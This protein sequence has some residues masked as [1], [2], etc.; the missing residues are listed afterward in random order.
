MSYQY[1][2][3]AT[4][5]LDTETYVKRD[6]DDQLYNG[7][8]QGK[9]CCVFNSRKTGKSSL[10]VQVVNR[11]QNE[12][13]KNEEFI[14]IEIDFSQKGTTS[15]TAEKWYNSLILDFKKKIKLDINIKTW[16]NAHDWLSP[17]DRFAEFIDTIVL[18]QTSKKIIVFFDEIDSLLSLNF[19]TDDLFSYIRSWHNQGQ[20]GEKNYQRLTCCLLGTATPSD[21]IQDKNRTSFNIGEE[22]ELK[23]FN[24]QQVE[25]LEKGFEGKV[26]HPLK[27]LE[28]IL[29]WTGGQPFLTQKLCKLALDQITETS[30]LNLDEL[31]NSQ[32]L[33]NW[34]VHDNP[35]HLRTIRD[36]L[37]KD[38]K[39]S[40][41]LLGI[42][43]QLLNSPNQTLKADDS[44]DQIKLRLSGLVVKKNGN[45]EVYNRIYQAVFNLNWVEKELANQR[46]F[47]HENLVAWRTSGRIDTRQLL[48]G[49]ILENALKEAE[50]KRLSDEDQDF[51]NASRDYDRQQLKQAKEK[52]TKI[53]Q[54]AQKGTQLERKGIQTLRLFNT[55]IDQRQTLRD[56][57]QAG[58]DLQQLQA[59]WRELVQDDPELLKQTPAASPVFTLPEILSHIRQWRQ[60]TGHS[61]SV[62]AVAFSPGGEFLATAS[63]D[64]TAKLW[65]LQGEEL[66]TFTGHSNSVW[67]VAFSPG[68]EFLATASHDKTAKLW[69][70]QGEELITFTGHSYGLRAVAFSPGGEFLATASGDKTAK[71]WNLQGEE[72]I[73]TFTGHSGSLWGVAFSPGGEFLATASYDKTAK[74][75]NLQGE[76]LITFTGHSD[77][78][79]GVAFSPGGEFLATA[80]WDNTT[81][82]WNLDRKSVV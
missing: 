52:A 68:G 69:N 29:S 1:I 64:K 56:A 57:I 72:L 32:I 34:E 78:L 28:Q 25:R 61:N 81:K 46:K 8:K 5:P 77:S 17:L 51:L 7:L 60:L 44:Y 71:L 13:F 10:R 58:E 80:S 42:Y 67:G 70:L 62:W 20:S 31:V 54:L 30:N 9:F 3:E 48:S 16:L 36:R 12:E 79:W 11:L 45:L 19:L 15:T 65:N 37:L 59:E 39:S 40:G 63:V 76:K 24:I 22:I 33:E 73:T 27:V 35:E 21:L 82:L 49:E 23:P 55:T 50:G 6:A 26:D 4:L 38:E 66:I 2:Y 43:Q 74:L 75:W 14:C 53:I 41:R 47:Y 18:P